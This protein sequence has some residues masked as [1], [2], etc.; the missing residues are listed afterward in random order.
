MDTAD[1]KACR[2]RT[3]KHWLH[4]A[5]S[6]TEPKDP[7]LDAVAKTTTAAAPNAKAWHSVFVI[8]GPIGKR[9]VG[10]SHNRFIHV[11]TKQRLPVVAGDCAVR[12][13]YLAGQCIPT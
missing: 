10:G 13:A 2:A 7:A 4:R 9:Q 5:S 3:L 6:H 11:S 8:F 1:L 12:A